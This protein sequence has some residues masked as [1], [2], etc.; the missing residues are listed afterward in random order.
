MK[1]AHT[2]DLPP[3]PQEVL[4]APDQQTVYVSCDQSAKVAAVSLSDWTVKKLIDAGP[5]ADG[6]AWAAK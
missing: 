4:I 6:L 1:V 3:R 2:V 5:G